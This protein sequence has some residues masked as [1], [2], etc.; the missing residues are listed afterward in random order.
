LGFDTSKRPGLA[1]RI[2]QMAGRNFVSQQ[3]SNKKIPT[4]EKLGFFINNI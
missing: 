2:F 1:K 3:S 4:V